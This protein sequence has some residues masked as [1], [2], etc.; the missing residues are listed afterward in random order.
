MLPEGEAPGSDDW[1]MVRENSEAARAAIASSLQGSIAKSLRWTDWDD[2]LCCPLH[3]LML[4]AACLRDCADTWCV[5]PS[6]GLSRAASLDTQ[7]D[8]GNSLSRSSSGM[9]SRASSGGVDPAPA[10]PVG[11]TAKSSSSKSKKGKKKADDDKK[12]FE[13]IQGKVSDV[14]KMTEGLVKSI[15]DQKWKDK[16]KRRLSR[17]AEGHMTKLESV[18]PICQHVICLPGCDD[19]ALLRLAL[20]GWQ[21][22]VDHR[23]QPDPFQRVPSDSSVRSTASHASRTSSASGVDTSNNSSDSSSSSTDA[24][25]SLD[26]HSSLQAQHRC[27]DTYVSVCLSACLFAGMYTAVYAYNACVHAHTYVCMYARTYVTPGGG[28]HNDVKLGD[29]GQLACSHSLLRRLARARL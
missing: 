6:T 12:L 21:Q 23:S 22:H 2:C 25:H 18:C 14:N 17:S 24:D 10:K 16:I 1:S 8:A 29:C 5:R 20:Q 4:G 19:L 11:K 27:L 3:A 7:T 9:L 13:S 15:S 26:P 28:G